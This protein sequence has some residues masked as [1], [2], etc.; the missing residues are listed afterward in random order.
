MS[1]LALSPFALKGKGIFELRVRTAPQTVST[2]Q[3]RCNGFSNLIAPDTVNYD[4]GRD[5]DSVGTDIEVFEF[6]DHM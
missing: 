1:P 6:Y 4:T 2:R 5:V 3:I